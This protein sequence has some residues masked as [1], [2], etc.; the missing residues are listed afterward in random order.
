V[1][2]FMRHTNTA[3]ALASQP[4]HTFQ[5]TASTHELTNHHTKHHT[6]HLTDHQSSIRDSAC[7][8]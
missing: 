7:T 4:T 3:S 2:V 5:Q 8:V 6:D 1:C